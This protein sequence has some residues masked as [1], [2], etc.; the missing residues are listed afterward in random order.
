[1]TATLKKGHQYYYCT[2]GKGNCEQHKKYLRSEELDKTLAGK[3]QDLKF[4]PKLVEIAY[5]AAKVKNNQTKSYLETARE[6]LSNRLHALKTKQERLLDVLCEGSVAS[7]VYKAKS[8][9]MQKEEIDLETQLNGINQ[10]IQR[11]IST[12]EQTKRVFLEANS[13]A[14]EFLKAKDERKRKLLEILLWNATFQNQEL[15]KVSYKVPY[16][17]LADEPNKDDFFKLRATRVWNPLFLQDSRAFLTIRPEP[18]FQVFGS[19]LENK[20]GQMGHRTGGYHWDTRLSYFNPSLDL[21]TFSMMALR[22]AR[23]IG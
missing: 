15:A 20:M 5:K 18:K 9:Q 22:P 2:N 10:K 4:N 23:A 17:F 6:G 11:G 19:N 13:G 3:F 12:L 7:V 14:N 16:Q 8:S 21:R 1:M